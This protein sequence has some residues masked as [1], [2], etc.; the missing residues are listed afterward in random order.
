MTT[1]FQYEKHELLQYGR[2]GYHWTLAFDNLKDMRDF[3]ERDAILR[4]NMA[5]L[6]RDD[7]SYIFE[8]G[9]ELWYKVHSVD[10]HEW[11]VVI[12]CVRDPFQGME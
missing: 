5:G 10:W 9:M 4:D 11:T 7:G 1:T 6:R 2:V 8:R 12:E 3:L